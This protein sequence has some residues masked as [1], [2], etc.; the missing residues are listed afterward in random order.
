MSCCDSRGSILGST[1]AF[2]YLYT[3][4][5]Q[6]HSLCSWSG[7]WHLEHQIGDQKFFS[8]RDPPRVSFVQPMKATAQV[9]PFQL[10]CLCLCSCFDHS[11]QGSESLHSGYPKPSMVQPPNSSSLQMLWGHNSPFSQ[12]IFQFWLRTLCS[13]VFCK[14]HPLFAHTK[15][16]LSCCAR[17]H[18]KAFPRFVGKF[19]QCSPKTRAAV[20]TLKPNPR[21][22]RK[23]SKCAFRE[24]C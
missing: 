13:G 6:I 3:P 19:F 7:R 5:M 18:F 16:L 21:H 2:L 24:R 15:R 1:L 8:L 17:Q 9:V 23:Q 22:L 12:L 20:Q 4:Q 11:C 14:A 10:Y